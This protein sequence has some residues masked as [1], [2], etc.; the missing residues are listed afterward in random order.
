MVVCELACYIRLFV[1]VK[2][3]CSHSWTLATAC[4]SHEGLMHLLVNGFTYFFMAPSVLS[5]L[6]DS[7]FLGLYLGG[8]SV[9]IFCAES[10]ILNAI[11]QVASS[12][13]QLVYSGIIAYITMENMHLMAPVVST[14]PHPRCILVLRHPFFQVLCTP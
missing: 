9:A 5:M 3:M 12:R 13:V 8:S 1:E 7:A 2:Y 4:F 6:G 11:L 10:R 14:Q